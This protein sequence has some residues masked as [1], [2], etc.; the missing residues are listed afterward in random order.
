MNMPL[1]LWGLQGTS[2]AVS[3]GK[4]SRAAVS[5][6]WLPWATYSTLKPTTADELKNRPLV[7]VGPQG[8]HAWARGRGLPGGQRDRLSGVQEERCAS[9]DLALSCS[10][11]SILQ[12][13]SCS[14]IQQFWPRHSVRHGAS[15]SIQGWGSPSRSP[16]GAAKFLYKREITNSGPPDRSLLPESF[17]RS[18]SCV[19]GTLS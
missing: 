18:C 12:G 4:Q 3:P 2:W 9:S 11:Y 7:C 8:G 13:L 16:L 10:N 1:A 17:G 6:F 5:H 19:E 15:A 14:L